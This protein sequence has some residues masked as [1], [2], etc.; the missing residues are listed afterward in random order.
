MLAIVR[1]FQRLLLLVYLPVFQSGPNTV[2]LCCFSLG[3]PVNQPPYERVRCG[4]RG[5]RVMAYSFVSLL[6]L[7]LFDWEDGVWRCCC[8]VDGRVIAKVG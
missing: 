2:V 4:T 5:P 1:P 3:A 7:A 6:A 8:G